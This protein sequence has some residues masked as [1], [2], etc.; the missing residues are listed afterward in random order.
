M[1]KVQQYII[2]LILLQFIF[3][4]WQ[5]IDNNISNAFILDIDI[6]NDGTMF[7]VD[8]YGN[9]LYKSINQGI[10][11]TPLNIQDPGFVFVSPYYSDDT[12]LFIANNNGLRKSNDGGESSILVSEHIKCDNDLYRCE[13]FFSDNYLNDGTIYIYGQDDLFISNDFGDTWDKIYGEN[14][15]NPVDE[16]YDENYDENH[17]GGSCYTPDLYE[18]NS[19]IT[20]NSDQYYFYLANGCASG[21]LSSSLGRTND[22]GATWDNIFPGQG[23]GQIIVSSPNFDIDSTLFFV[24]RYASGW[25]SSCGDNYGE[26]GFF[27]SQ[28]NGESWDNISLDFISPG[29]SGQSTNVNYIDFFEMT[30]D[31]YL[32]F[33]IAQNKKTFLKSEDEGLSWINLELPPSADL[34]CGYSEALCMSS[35]AIS[36]YDSR[37]YAGFNYGC[38]GGCGDGLWKYEILPTYGCTHPNASNYNPEA[39]EDDGS[40]EFETV[41]IGHQVWMTENLKTTHYNNGDAIPTG[42]DNETWTSTEEGAYAVYDDDPA[43]AE[44]Y[45]NLYN[46]Y[47]AYDDRGVC[48]E[49]WHVPL[50]EEFDSLFDFLGGLEISGGKIKE[51]TQGDCPD[52]DYWIPPNTGATNEVG[53]DA[54]PTGWRH[55]NIGLDYEYKGE[56]TAFWSSEESPENTNNST[57]FMTWNTSNEVV[58]WGQGKKFGIPIRCLSDELLNTTIHVPEDF[59]T[60]QAAIDYS[61]DG[62]SILVSAGIYYENI[63][64]N[65][66]NI[67]VIG[68]DRETTIIDGGQNGSVVVFE[69]DESSA[70]LDGF[71]LTNGA[72]S[73]GGGGIAIISS[74]PNL[75]NLIIENNSAE[76]DGGGIDIIGNNSSQLSNLIVRNN[77]SQWGAGIYLHGD[78]HYDNSPYIYKVEV[79]NNY[80]STNAGGVYVRDGATPVME[81]MTIVNNVTEGLGGGLLTWYHTSEASVKNCIIHYNSPDNVASNTGGTSNIS[82]SNIGGGYV[83]QDN[84]NED[85]KLNYDLTLQSSSPCIDA[86]DPESE[87]DP[88][89]TIADMGAYYYHQESNYCDEGYTDIDEQCL[90]IGDIN[91]DNYIDIVDVVTIIQITLGMYEPTET[92]YTLSDYNSD[93]SVDISD[94]I[95]IIGYILAN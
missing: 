37:I 90:L 58:K 8:W 81:N 52:S 22:A 74:S 5:K 50:D 47:A 35:V 61:I 53:F 20:G 68:E 41:Q 82:F 13:S 15:G 78:V 54:L 16:N 88:D 92:E 14:N 94:I 89:G 43:N 65:G 17:P 60:I 38:G 55:S 67:S 84:I 64:F 45:G 42:L 2:L 46:W 75:N 49:G 70:L 76:W 12:T 26:A 91:Q 23:N 62:D 11:F 51:C 59:P 3:S 85:P 79:S 83:G 10:S 63:N 33:M 57:Q 27:K 72:N 29:L 95:M 30:D 44:V 71:T 73:Y 21:C 56:L 66:K 86:G 39:N 25:S 36:D 28:N 18:N 69:N 32:I 34:P 77:V 19:L 93:G 4:N 1:R 40:C 24:T 6:A 48:P 87:L 9:P 80:A 7:V 31:E